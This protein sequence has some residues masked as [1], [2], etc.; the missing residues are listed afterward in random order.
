M[1]GCRPGGTYVDATVGLGGHAEAMAERIAPGGKLIVY[2]GETSDMAYFI[3]IRFSRL[4]A[5][6]SSLTPIRLLCM[7][8]AISSML[9]SYVL[10]STG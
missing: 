4:S 10:L 9:W 5:S 6:V 7:A 8:L 3:L 1:I 2:R